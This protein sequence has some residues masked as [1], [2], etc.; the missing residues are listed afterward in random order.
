MSVS[1]RRRDRAFASERGRR[2]R[3]EER[4]GRGGETRARARGSS[5]GEGQRAVARRERAGRGR[6]TAA[7]ERSRRAGRRDGRRRERV[8]RVHRGRRPMGDRSGG[9][10]GAERGVFEGEHQTARAHPPG[11]RPGADGARGDGRVAPAP[12]ARTARPRESVRGS[13][14]GSRPRLRRRGR[15]RV[16]R[17][18]RAS[19]PSRGGDA[20]TGG[21]LCGEWRARRGGNPS[22]A[23]VKRRMRAHV[24]R[25]YRGVRDPADTHAGRAEHPRVRVYVYQS[26]ILGVVVESAPQ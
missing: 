22:A 4:K 14:A 25:G 10:P 9:G 6:E 8:R 2:A 13:R 3:A 12:L 15:A 24:V 19:A 5:R 18:S 11:G 7:G 16:A 21:V 1:E 26:P 20:R 23:D 17:P